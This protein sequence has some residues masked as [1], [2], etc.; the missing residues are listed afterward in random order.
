VPSRTA[1]V[2]TTL[3][4]NGRDRREPVKCHARK[5]RVLLFGAR[6]AD[7]IRASSH[8]G[9]IQRPNTWL[10]PNAS[11]KCQIFPLHRRRRPYMALS[12]HSN[13]SRVCPLL[14]VVSTDRRNTLSLTAKMECVVISQRFRRGFTAAE[15]TE[16]WD[17]WQRGESLKAIGRAFGKPSSSIYCQLAPHGGI[18]PA[19]RRPIQTAWLFLVLPSTA[20]VAA[21]TKEAGAAKAFITYLTTPAA[22]A[23][24]KVKGMNP[25]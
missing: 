16:L 17:R 18:R 12:G 25:G 14:E 10:H 4:R 11:L 23:V 13:R 2:M 6:S 24:I 5:E 8:N 1:R 3:M 20:A 7:Y 19:P 22:A 21:D 9:C 15:K